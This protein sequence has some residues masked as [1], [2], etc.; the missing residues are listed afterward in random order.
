MV[1]SRVEGQLEM[2]L[3]FA[4]RSKG[5]WLRYSQDRSIANTRTCL[6][7][8]HPFNRHR[9]H[10]SQRPS[11]TVTAELDADEVIH[12]HSLLLVE[13]FLDLL[14]SLCSLSLRNAG[15]IPSFLIL[16]SPI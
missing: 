6:L 15:G 10:S 9:Y 13:R 7:S 14:V 4:D 12:S 16:G 1:D 2:M 8:L 11:G 5:F 3:S